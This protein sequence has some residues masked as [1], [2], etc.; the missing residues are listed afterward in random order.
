MAKI[1]LGRIKL[2]F[3]GEYDRE[4]LYRRDDIVYHSNAMWI[5]TNE[6]LADGSSAYAPGSKVVGY[7]VK[8]RTGGNWSQDP[9]YNGADAFN[10]TQYW[11]ENERKGER[12]RTD[13]DGN[14]IKYNSTYGSNEEGA[15]EQSWNQIDTAL[16]TVVRH[17]THLMDEYDSMFRETEDD[18]SE[19]D[20]YNGYE[21]TYFRYHYRPIDNSFE[22]QVSISGGVADFKIDNRL[23][24]DTKGRQFAGYRNFEFVRE[25]H[26]YNFIQQKNSNKYYPIGFSYTADGIHNANNL[27]KS[28]GQDPDGPYYVKGTTSTGDSG[29]FSP[30]YKTEAS[31]IAED[32]RRGGGGA[33]HK[34]TFDQG[35]VPGWE[36]QSVALQGHKHADGT[37]RKDTQVSVLTDASNNTYLQVSNS[38]KGTTTGGVASSE[39]KTIYLHTGD[40]TEHHAQTGTTYSYVY[41]DGALQVNSNI[42]AVVTQ[43][44]DDT[45]TLNAGAGRQ[46][47]LIN[48][49]PVYQL[50]AEAS[51]VVVG[52]ISGD[53]Q[54]IDKTGTGTT[55]ALGSTP[56]SNE[57]KI[58]LYMPKLTDSTENT[59]RTFEVSVSGSKFHIDGSLATAETV[60]LEEGKT[61]KFDQ[62]DS[63]NAGQTLT[64]S[65]TSDGTHASGS[66][67]TT[68]VT[69]YGTP[70]SAGA[71]T[72]IKLQAGVAKLY[73]YS[74]ETASY[75]FATETYDMSANL[76]KSYAPGN[77]PK[78]RGYGKNGWVKYYLDGYQ[79]DENTYIECF[80]KSDQADYD[81]QYPQEM[82]NGRWKGG[83]QYNFL[84]K[85]ER[86]VELTVPYQT[87]QSEAEK[88]VI[89][90]FCLEPTTATRATTGM[91]NSS[92]FSIEKS[93][94][95]F[96]HWDKIQSSLRFRG[97][98]ST[99]TQYNYNDVVSYKPF[100]KLT[101]EKWYTQGTGLYKAIRDSKGRPPQHGHQEPTRSPLMT[102][103][104]VTAG[105]LTGYGEHENNNTTGKNYP[106]H[107]Q[108]YH[109]AWESFAGMNAQEQCAG[110][111]FPNR[112]PIGWPF[113]H[114]RSES[115]NTYRN[116]MYIDKNGALWT[117]G[118]GS[119]S[120]DMHHARSSSYFR[121]VCF[122]WRDF[123]NSES[124]NEGGYNNRR[125]PK[126]SR[127][128]RMR[129]PRC[130]QIEQG[131]DYTTVLFDNGELFH[132]GYGGHGQQGTGFDGNPNVPVSPDGVENVHFI[133]IT[134]N[135]QNED[136]THTICCLTDEGDV[137]TWGF[138]SYGE[139]GDGRA[140]HTYGP[141][142]IPREW[143]NDEK[144]IDI[145]CQ[146]TDGTSFYARTS[147]DNIYAWGYNNIGQLGDT[148]TVNKYRPILQTGF[149]AS[150]NGGI[151]VWQANSGTSHSSF[152]ILDGDGY[153]WSTG[154]N[155]YSHFFDNT[156]TD[157]NTM[158]KADIAPGGD[159]VDFWTMRYNGYHTS[160]VRLKNGETWTAGF[161]GTYY[162]SGDGGQGTNTAPV[163]VDKI[164]NLKEVALCNTY[165]DQCRSYWL[166]DNG[167]FF[168][169]GRDV[170][171]SMPN[172]L[173]GDSWNGEDGTYKPYHAYV[174]AG[175]RIRTMCIQGIDQGT[176][177]YG[178]QPWVGTE[179][180]Q[181]LLWGFSNA[182]N[183]G[184]HGPATYSNTGRP[185]M[186]GACNGR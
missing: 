142:R 58:E 119:S 164:N 112:G 169:Q 42:T 95:G 143:F 110:V 117:I 92:G 80:F 52:G 102:K 145:T 120:S 171:E 60:K 127:Y 8:E 78:W 173:A 61:Y 64:F 45:T 87:T 82:D 133:K 57:D 135:I 98:Y 104:S 152:H 51:T 184:H 99:N 122:R 16:G 180:G 48:G 12:Q 23:G 160:F 106:P 165:S 72:I 156:T 14:P 53:Y 161:S 55:T 107:I 172:P 47:L 84:N 136:S 66:A 33:A 103:S 128:D 67:Y 155:N 22:V 90:P 76:G 159:I 124:R 144:I 85:G 38:W 100:K 97:E 7:N 121:E 4:Q 186:W 73:T 65:T 118:E 32:T 86:T 77:L 96:K 19:M 151:A 150:D 37:Q 81:Y 31:A 158:T 1:N 6:Y 70:G 39:R 182:N 56:T 25:G 183:L 71:H 138:N 177:Y 174:P 181:C 134:H 43:S 162:N 111:W 13:Q 185:L 75:G 139:V 34:L 175:T 126:W 176:S 21:Q 178:L 116:H 11:T 36:T 26:R 83:N 27:G 147:Q 68:G 101:N 24:S 41:V 49:K 154:Y 114:G 179:D 140:T 28:L 89:Y 168:C 17:Q 18:Y 20:T 79:V 167:E 141:K 30:M 115:A 29:F 44:R 132:G 62:S 93:W 146:G 40:T 94:R 170:Y 130:I 105:K 109:N 59:E 46:R 88:T 166:T 2:Q 137:Y 35:D 113:K 15:N 131:Y 148:T 69:H 125:G 91:Y 163:Q 3:Q 9:D 50:V 10:Y 153:I 123:Y 108:S 157:R 5:L 74:A 63:T 129:T 149:N 54:G